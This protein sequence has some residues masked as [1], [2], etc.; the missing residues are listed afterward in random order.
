MKTIIQDHQAFAKVGS[1]A[2]LVPFCAFRASSQIVIKT[3]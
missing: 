3:L 1:L 2:A